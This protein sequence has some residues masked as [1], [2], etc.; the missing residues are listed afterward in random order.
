MAQSKQREGKSRNPW[1]F[2][3]A[4]LL[5]LAT[6]GKTVLLLLGKFAGPL[7]SMGITIGAYAL[8][9]PIWFAIGFVMLILVHELGHVLAAKR[10]GLPVSAPLFIP[11][12]G[13]LI[14]MKRH[15]KDAVT[16]AYIAYGGPLIGT[17]GALAVYA[18]G[19]LFDNPL[20]FVLA[21]VGFLI[22]LF[23]LLPIHPLDGG[24]IATAVSRWLWV[25]GLIG[26][27][28]LIV[29]WQSFL[30]ILIWLYFAWTMYQTYIKSSK[31]SKP[32][33]VGGVY[34]VDV[35]HLQLPDWYLSG[36][37]HKRDLPFTSY[38]KLTGEHMV[39]FEWDVINFRGELELPV[40]ATVRQVRLE[41]SRMVQKEDGGEKFQI[42]VRVDYDKYEND[43]Y[44]EV[45][46]TTRWKFGLAYGGLA[47]FLMFMMWN[48]HEMGLS[49]GIR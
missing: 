1:W 16:E 12:V 31:K 26:G 8:I 28:V 39:Q 21:N 19:Y 30:L 36:Q 22:N 13:A 46:A 38:C 40:P 20:L 11:F 48:I 41:K 14:T 4:A 3:G 27:A 23:N 45:P 6:K 42:L 44:Y 7:I 49:Q 37:E 29:Y 9:S 15:P 5:F 10:K 33:Y 24:R 35:R 47:L 25:V 34:E 43:R 17:I 32:L 2:I 18:A